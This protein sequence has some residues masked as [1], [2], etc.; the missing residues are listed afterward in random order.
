MQVE[1]HRHG[2]SP[3]RQL[4][5]LARGVCVCGC[6]FV[7]VCVCVCGCVF[8]CVGVWWWW[9][10]WWWWWLWVGRGGRRSRGV[11]VV[12]SGLPQAPPIPAFVT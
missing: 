7:W 2:Q 12:V 6:V 9:W 8:V 5:V 1:M 4:G 10:W 3:S 11:L